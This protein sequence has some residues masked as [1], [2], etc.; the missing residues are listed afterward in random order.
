MI[1]RA[2]TTVADA[3][4]TPEPGVYITVKDANGDLA[5]LYNDDGS[6]L[7]NPFQSGIGGAFVYNISDDDEGAFTEE[8]RLTLGG[9]PKVVIEVTLSKS[10]LDGLFINA[11]SLNEIGRAH[12]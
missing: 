3:G 7:S 2:D 5:T 6:S 8:Y 4:G 12:V 11:S 9:N 1:R 10:G